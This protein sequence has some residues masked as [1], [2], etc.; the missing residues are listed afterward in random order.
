MSMFVKRFM[1]A[2]VMIAAV[3]TAILSF[4][5]SLTF[6]WISAIA[7]A[8][9][10]KKLNSNESILGYTG[11]MTVAFLA[12]MLV[13]FFV[14]GWKTILAATLVAVIYLFGG[15]KID[16]KLGEKPTL[17]KSIGAIGTIF[18]II[19]WLV[20][21][22]SV[23]GMLLSWLFSVVIADPATTILS[24]VVIVLLIMVIRMKHELKTTNG[25]SS[26]APAAT[27]KA[28]GASPSAPRKRP[29]PSMMPKKLPH[30]GINQ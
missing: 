24:I 27:I 2:I 16:D 15:H 11:K 19:P 21:I 13:D 6:G 9:M 18:A 29:H 23:L 28:P 26:M 5:Y 7:G 10:N 20:K 25:S 8:W 4:T 1:P 30:R 14:D 12:G 17:M 3:A 22:F